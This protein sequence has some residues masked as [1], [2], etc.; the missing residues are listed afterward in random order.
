MTQNKARQA[1]A[2]G[3]SN[4]STNPRP[5]V[6][7]LMQ[8]IPTSIPSAT[9]ATETAPALTASELDSVTAMLNA[10]GTKGK[11]LADLHDSCRAMEQYVKDID[12]ELKDGF[13]FPYARLQYL[14]TRREVVLKSLYQEFYTFAKTAVELAEIVVN[15]KFD[16]CKR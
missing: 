11:H 6:M 16:T 5:T 9:G 15:T 4:M 12:Q 13:D 2:T 7:D 8:Q 14:C 3:N 10:T 1:A